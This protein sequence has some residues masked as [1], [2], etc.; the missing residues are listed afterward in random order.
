LSVD[1]FTRGTHR[2]LLSQP[3]QEAAVDQGHA[4]ASSVFTKAAFGS[5][6]VG[7]IIAF[8]EITC[9]HMSKTSNVAK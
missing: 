3:N 1:R 6:I 8:H 4:S 2:A 5:G 9:I 7:K